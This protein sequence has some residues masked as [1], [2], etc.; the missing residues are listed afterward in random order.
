ML[1]NIIIFDLCNCGKVLQVGSEGLKDVRKLRFI[2]SVWVKKLC[3]YFLGAL[4][5]FKCTLESRYF[6]CRWLILK[7]RGIKREKEMVSL[8]IW[9]SCTMI[10]WGGW[11]CVVFD[12]CGRKSIYWLH[13]RLK[14]WM[15]FQGKW[16]IPY[17]SRR[18]N[19]FEKA[20]SSIHFQFEIGNSVLLGGLS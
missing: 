12:Q 20:K 8:Q 9:K 3:M 11:C 19:R 4:Y 7:C 14:V 1:L 5:I 15:L 18:I 17:F 16:A 6:C 13:A 10:R 2:D